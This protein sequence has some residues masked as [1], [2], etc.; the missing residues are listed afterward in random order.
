MV[1]YHSLK[2]L[3]VMAGTVGVLAACSDST[4]L[5]GRQ[6]SLSFSGVRPA[7]V[8]PIAGV[9][10]VAGGSSILT[11][12]GDSLVLTDGTNTLII[13]KVEVLL[14]E[15]ELKR[16]NTSDCDSTTN[17]DACEKFEAGARLV[18]VPLQ[19]AVETGVTVDV[20]SGTYT[21]IEFDIHKLGGDAV[22][23]AF[24]AANP[25]WPANTS[26]RVTGFYNGTAFTFL[27][28]LDAEQEIQFV[29]PLVVSGG[30]VSA[31]VTMRFDLSLWF[32]NGTT[33]PLISPATANQGGANKSLVDNNIKNTI[34]AFEDD[35]MDG[36]ERDG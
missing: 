23:N 17:A 9:L 12:P 34:K 14:R 8:S 18:T 16:A 7:G 3:S 2:R 30:T 33:G 1:S 5:N 10:P 20:D 29:P 31:N 19:Q 4:A 21:E 35:D 26:I 15:V 13:T 25:T 22:D 36:D 27:T 28:D 6:M 24:A 32:R 11:A